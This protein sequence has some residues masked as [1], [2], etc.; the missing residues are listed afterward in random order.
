MT[1][2]RPATAF[3]QGAKRFPFLRLLHRFLGTEGQFFPFLHQ[4]FASLL[5]VALHRFCASGLN[6]DWGRLRA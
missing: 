6:M 1:D 4:N 3:E 5:R 2:T